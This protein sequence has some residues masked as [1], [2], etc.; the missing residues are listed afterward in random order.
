MDVQSFEALNLKLNDAI[1]LQN[2]QG[3]EVKGF[4]LDE[5][6][7]AGRTFGFSNFETGQVETIVIDNLAQLRKD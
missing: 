1:T 3:E 7:T 2:P 6:D 4:Y 5:Y